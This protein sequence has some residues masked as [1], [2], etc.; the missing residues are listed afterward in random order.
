MRALRTPGPY[1]HLRVNTLKASR[2]GVLEALRGRGVRAEGHPVLRDVIRIPIEGPSPL[3]EAEKLI[4]VDKFTAESV[5]MGAHVYA[6]GVVRCKGLRKGD[7][8]AVADEVGDVVAVGVARMSETEILKLRRGLAIEVTHPLYR[9]PPI[10]ETPEYREGLIYPQS[11]PS[12]LTTHILDPKPG[13]TIVD[14]NCGPGGKL[15]H[16]Y[17]LVGG[18]AKIIGV[19]RSKRKIEETRRN[20]QRLGCEGVT[21]IAHDSRYLDIDYPWIRADRCLVDPPC[22]ALGVTPKLYDYKS[23]GQIRASAEYQRQFLKV[24]SR[25]VKPGGVVVYSV[26]TM[27]VEECEGNAKFVVERCGLRLEEQPI[28]LGSPGLKWVFEGAELTQRFHPHIHG[29]GYFIARF[30][31]PS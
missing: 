16:A 25:M 6:P 21:L 19:D 14:L 24:A 18:E 30:R 4:V 7:L 15:T 3:P 10:R 28:M 26:C 1:Y 12:I 8:V 9:A 11:L 20:L 23:Y 17:Q 27:T 31:K 13:E 2:D 22:S 5:V 29:V